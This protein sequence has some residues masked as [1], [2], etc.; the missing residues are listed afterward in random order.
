MA[1]PRARDYPLNIKLNFKF[2]Y[3]IDYQKI[4]RIVLKEVVGSS[5]SYSPSYKLFENK[6][7]GLNMISIPR[8]LSIM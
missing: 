8:K 1:D 2:Y 5:N 6:K 3:I 4:P 7:E